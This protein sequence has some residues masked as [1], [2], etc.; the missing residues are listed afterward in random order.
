MPRQSDPLNPEKMH[1]MSL[2]MSVADIAG[3]TMEGYPGR[4]LTAVELTVGEL[5][6]VEIETFRTALDA[7]FRSSRWPAAV[8]EITVV[9]GESCCLNCGC[10]FASSTLYS[11]CPDCG[12]G[13]CSVVAG[14]EFKVDAVRMT[15]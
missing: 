10:R 6:G 4:S 9:P 1:E 2:A 7:V 5:A 15:D 3:R 14:T 13:A 12:S 11:V 8:A